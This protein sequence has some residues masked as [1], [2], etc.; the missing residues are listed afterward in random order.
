MTPS[1]S[2]SKSLITRPIP[3]TGEALPVIGL[4]TWQ[5]FDVG[6]AR[7]SQRTVL[8]EFLRGGGR[9][10]DSSPMYGRSEEVVGDLLAELKPSSL[11]SPPFLATKVWTRGKARGEE[12]MQRSAKRM[13]TPRL[14]L[15]QIHNLLDWRVH[16]PT[17]R[18]WKHEGRVRFIGATHYQLGA[19]D[20][21]EQIV[22]REKIDFV[23]L[24]YSMGVRDAEKRLLPAAAHHGV[25]VL[26]MRPFEEGAL[27]ARVRG[28]EIPPWITAALGATSWAEVFLKF[29]LGHPAVT[30][31]IPATANPA[32]LAQN[33]RAGH[34]PL[35]DEA[36]RQR[37]IAHLGL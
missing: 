32:H 8:A 5:T 21:L 30:C 34:G 15:L 1:P 37:L 4:G 27:F 28:K 18:A 12:E 13:R 19:F 23:Q 33:L 36:L 25:A 29:I 35:P 14:D 3:S 20:E 24:P 26:V 11:P 2:P 6:A 16:L 9:V 22:S 31:P 7:E 10:I 17:L